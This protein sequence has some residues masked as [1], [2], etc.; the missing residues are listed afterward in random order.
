MV[1]DS[2]LDIAI[3]FGGNNAD[4]G[5]KKDDLWV[6]DM[7]TD[8]WEELQ[9]NNPA[10]RYWYLAAHNSVNHEMVIFRGDVLTSGY[11]SE[12]MND[13]WKFDYVKKNW[14]EITGPGP[15][16]RDAGAMVFDNENYVIYG[17]YNEAGILDDMWFLQDDVW[18]RSGLESTDQET[19]VNALL[20]SGIC[21]T[22]F[23]ET[24]QN[25]EIK[26]LIIL[27]SRFCSILN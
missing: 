21:C 3:L 25:K 6:F 7:S 5:G 1:S 8:N 19:P 4:T 15:A 24:N 22:C 9:I 23:I 10:P 17:G 2:Q 14:E 26:A 20:H 16:V 12:I 18:E 27:E 11:S 13:T